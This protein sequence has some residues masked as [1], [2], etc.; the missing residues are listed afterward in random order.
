MSPVRPFRCFDSRAIVAA[1]G[2]AAWLIASAWLSHLLAPD[3]TARVLLALGQAGALAALVFVPLRRSITRLDELGRHIHYQALAVTAALLVTAITAWAF[4][5]RAG[6]PHIDW[7]IYAAPA[8]TVAW[9]IGVVLI[10][11]R[12]E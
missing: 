6:L 1:L 4:L 2:V 3:S 8:F 7:S 5:E 12:Y 9:A 10:A 11:R